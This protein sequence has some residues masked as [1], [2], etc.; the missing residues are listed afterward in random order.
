M[1]LLQI[2][3][4]RPSAPRMAKPD[5]CRCSRVHSQSPAGATASSRL[6]APKIS[7]AL[8]HRFFS[9]GP[10]SRCPRI[11]PPEEEVARGL[12]IFAE[13]FLIRIIQPPS[14]FF[15]QSNLRGSRKIS[16]KSTEE[17]P[18]AAAAREG[19]RTGAGGSLGAPSAG[20][21]AHLVVI[22]SPP[23][24]TPLADLA[25]MALPSLEVFPA[26]P[27]GFCSVGEHLDG[28]CLI[29]RPTILAGSYSV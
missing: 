12:G 29:S 26:W 23:A 9:M 3:E 15:K 8:L 24:E 17:L 21:E 19:K 13:F 22:V 20:A 18:A 28:T 27:L 10:F 5:H 11:D 4:G 14:G 2:A 6:G 16:W 1:V 25:R 7:P